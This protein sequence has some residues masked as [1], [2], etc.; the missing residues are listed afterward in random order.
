M[1][2][3]RDK[4]IPRPRPRPK[5]PLGSLRPLIPFATAY[6][7]RIL[8]AFLA[9]LAASAATLVVPIAV[10]RVIDHGFSPEGAAR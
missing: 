2:R 9:L 3:G 7:G 5:A 6:R 10:R 8:A 4:K 1:A